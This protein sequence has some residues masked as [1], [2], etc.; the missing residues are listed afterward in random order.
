M[1]QPG[2]TL[3]RNWTFLLVAVLLA[4]SMRGY[5]FSA[6]TVEA[7]SRTLEEPTSARL[8]KLVKDITM[9]KLLDGR[10]IPSPREVSSPF[11]PRAA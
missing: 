5:L 8:S 1:R 11:K 10:T 3:P 9:R 4:C 2:T 7:A 6:D